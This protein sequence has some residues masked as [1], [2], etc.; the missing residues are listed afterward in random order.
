MM[1]EEQQVLIRPSLAW[2]WL[3]LNVVV[4]ILIAGIYRSP[5]HTPDRTDQ[6]DRSADR[7]MLTHDFQVEVEPSPSF[8]AHS[9]SGTAI[10]SMLENTKPPV[11]ETTN[12]NESV[13]RRFYDEVLNQ[14][15]YAAMDELFAENVF[16][17]GHDMAATTLSVMAFRENLIADAA[18]FTGRHYT[19]NN[20]IVEADWVGVR[21]SAEGL[22]LDL[23]PNLSWTSQKQTW[24]GVTLWQVIDG[25]LVAGWTM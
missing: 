21:W 15:H 22:P 17:R 23:A 4:V 2:L 11:I 18:R 6:A 19:I 25:K 8:P 20:V 5:W 9:G 13:V 14:G 10:A 24:S 12:P 7:S 1:H 3:I 16:Y